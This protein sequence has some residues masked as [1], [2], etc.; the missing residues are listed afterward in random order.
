MGQGAVGNLLVPLVFTNTGSVPCTLKGYPGVS[1]VGAN[2]LQIGPA[3]L[4]QDQNLQPLVSLAPAQTT[5]AGFLYPD[6]AEQCGDP[7]TEDGLRVYPPN[8]TAALFAPYTGIQECP[9]YP[10][11]Q[12]EIDPI[13]Q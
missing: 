8:Q 9:G 3:A 7:V 10:P 12:S 1:I 6:M 11:D 2:G 13:G 4:R 5:S